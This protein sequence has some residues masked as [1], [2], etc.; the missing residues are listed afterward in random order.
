VHNIARF[1]RQ[2]LTVATDLFLFQGWIWSLSSVDN[3]LAT[4]SWD[5]MV[6]FWDL[7]VGQCVQFIRSALIKFG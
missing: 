4:G 5:M 6:K 1:V 3:V 2:L 7:D